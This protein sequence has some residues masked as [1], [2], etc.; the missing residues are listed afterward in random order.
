[1]KS[2]QSARKSSAD[3]SQVPCKWEGVTGWLLLRRCYS[4]LPGMRRSS[5]CGWNSACMS[6][7]FGCRL[8]DLAL[9]KG[10]SL[11]L[12]RSYWFVSKTLGLSCK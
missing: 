12:D 11:A 7:F 8:S 5:D 3:C 4:C 6:S 1:M 9:M 2:G 10:V